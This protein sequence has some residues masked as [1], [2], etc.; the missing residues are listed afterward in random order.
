MQTSPWRRAVHHVRDTAAL[1]GRALAR[2]ARRL[3]GWARARRRTAL[4]QL[5][6]GI[7]FGSGS[8]LITLIVFWLTHR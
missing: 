5:L 6:R 7:C 1:A 2:R 4:S 8:G 3:R